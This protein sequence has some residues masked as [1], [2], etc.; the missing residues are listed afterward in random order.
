MQ[1]LPDF[2][3][4]NQFG[5]TF[6]SNSLKGKPCVIYFYPKDDTPGCTAEACTFRDNFQAFA[7]KGVEVVGISKDS[8]ESHKKFAEKYKIPFQLLADTR[9]LVTKMFTVKGN[10]FGLI[11][12]RETFIFDEKGELIHR[13]N[14]QFNATQHV[15]EA[16][17][18]LGI[19][20]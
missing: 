16:L 19:K 12:G 18:K 7:D 6:N 2:T 5:E 3:L 4:K 8:V 11:P 17:E 1:T 15:K 10:L 20:N 9:G 13:F 14:S